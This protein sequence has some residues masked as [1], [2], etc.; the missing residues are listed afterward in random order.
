MAASSNSVSTGAVYLNVLGVG[1]Y[2]ANIGVE[3]GLLSNRDRS[4]LMKS[5]LTQAV[6]DFIMEY[7]PKRFQKAYATFDLGWKVKPDTYRKKQRRARRYPEAANPNTWT[8]DTKRMVMSSRLDV[9]SV[10][11]ATKGEVAGKIKYQMPGYINQQRSQITNDTVR[12]ITAREGKWIADKFFS[13]MASVANR[14]QMNFEGRDATFRVRG[15]LSEYDRARM[16]FTSRA[17]QVQP[18][19]STQVS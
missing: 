10:G 1:T 13:Y 17:S 19:N 8:G 15:S 9:R 14:V 11:G 3:V 18:R 4:D 12:K 7:M 16:Q 5:C 6:D 2:S